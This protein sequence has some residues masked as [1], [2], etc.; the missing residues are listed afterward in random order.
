MNYNRFYLPI[1]ILLTTL[2]ACAC[3][4]QSGQVVVSKAEVI[5]QPAFI[6]YGQGYFNLNSATP[7]LYPENDVALEKT[8]RLLQGFIKASLGFEPE[9]RIGDKQAEGIVLVSE[10]KGE[11]EAY[12]L[13]VN[14]KQILITGASAKGAF[15][16]IQTLRQL[17]PAHSDKVVRIAAMH[18][19]D[20]PRFS[21]RGMHLDV[22]RHFFDTSFVKQYIDL[23]AMHKLNTFH[24]HLT[25]DQGWRIEIKQY[26]KLTS[27]GSKR[28]ETLVGHADRSKEY[29]GQPYGGY[30]TQD[31]IKEVIKYASDRYITIIPEIEMPGHALAALS[32]YPE[33]GCTGGPYEAATT[34]GVFDDVFCAGNDSTFHFIENVLDEVMALFPSEYIHVGGDECP[35]ASWEKCAKCQARI[36]AEGLKNE[37]ELQS[38]FITRMEKYLNSKGR[39]II[40]WDEILEGGLAPNATVMSWRGMEGGIDAAKSKHNVIMAPNSHM[41]FDAYQSLNKETEPLAI[42]GYLNVEKVYSFEPVPEALEESEQGYIIGAQANLWTEYIATP[43]HVEYMVLPRMAALSEVLWSDKKVRDI[44]SFKPRLL[45]LINYYGEMRLNYA[46]HI[47]DVDIETVANAETGKVEV[48][49][50]SFSNGE[51]YYTIDGSEPDEKSNQ[52][53]GKVLEIDD[54]SVFKAVSFFNNKKG[55][56]KTEAIPLSKSSFKPLTLLSQPSS[57]YQKFV[58]ALNDGLRGTMIFGNGAWVGINQ[59]NLEALIDLEKKE[60]VSRVK[61]GTLVQAGSW[62]MG[63]RSL[64]VYSSYD[65]QGFTLLAAKTYPETKQGSKDTIVDLEV[66]FEAVNTQYLKVVVERQGKLPTWHTG[67]GKNA[68]LFV[69][70]II[71]E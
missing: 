52:Y 62:I 43:E 30:Y 14:D 55:V 26:P 56:T 33:L 24:W 53:T 54:N 57:R 31:E 59:G 13:E 1:Y 12:E 64:K 21:Y 61:V 23:I 18:I 8:A 58:S 47:F 29:D 41:Y 20:A 67:K 37:H 11:A 35:K 28:K 32:A 71:V 3:Q 7:I 4:V 40:G 5:P 27:I 16:G 17:I 36:K 38:Y 60:P 34:F 6:E 25:D 50:S 39:Q 51:L 65:G 10:N 48:K 9:V 68:Y 46:K 49:L 69:D 19:K 45:H 63:A 42:G 15:Y 66:N 70:E 44:D 2:L 22:S